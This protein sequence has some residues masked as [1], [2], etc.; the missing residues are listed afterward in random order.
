M[1]VEDEENWK[2]LLSC[3]ELD[4]KIDTTLILPPLKR[5]RNIPAA[6]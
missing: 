4:E 5:Q 2:C 1:S 3:Q 6:C